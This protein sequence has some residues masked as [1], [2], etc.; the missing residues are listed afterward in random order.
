MDILERIKEIKEKLNEAS[1]AYYVN[2]N[3]IMDDYE[4]DMLMEELIRLEEE[5]PSLKTLDSP[6]QRIGGEV[7]S[8]FKKVTHQV[9]MMSLADA[10]SY[11]ELREWDKRVKAVAADATYCVE[12]KIDG[13]SVSLKYEDG[14]LVQ[15]A[16][17]GNGT[18]GED[19]THNV[20]TIKSV[21]LK[22]KTPLTT[23][24]RG[25]IFMPKASFI[26]LNLEREENE[27]E[28]FANCRNAAAGSV[29][30]L[31]SR[32]AAKR[33]L[34]T[35]L[36]YYLD[37]NV[38]TQV[39][40]LEDMKRLGFKVNPMYRHCKTMDEVISYIEEM[41]KKRPDLPY[42]IDGI[43]LKVNEINLH[44]VIGETVKYPKWAIAY[45]F[46]PE[47]V[48]TELLDITYQV[49]RTG[50][51]TPVANF[52][53][54]FVQGSSISK[55]TLHNEDY[56]LQKDVRI[57]DTIVIRKAG[58]VIPEVVK[59]IPEKRDIF[60]IPFE[61]IKNC[62]CCGTPLV[63]K[64]SEADWYCMNPNC[65]DKLINKLI[66]FASKP[67]YNIDSLGDKLCQQ[68][69]QAGFIKRI[70]DIFNLR[71]NYDNLIVLP[72]LGEKSIDHLLDAIEE[73]K[74]N[75]L[76]Q[77]I[78]GLGIRHV[79]AK[80]AKSLCKKYKNIDGL[81]NAT[82]EDTVNIPDIGEVIASDFI[83]W[84]KNEDNRSLIE[85]LRVLG[86]NME[87]DLGEIK[88]NYFTGKKCVLTGTLS[89]MGRDEAKKLIESFGGAL[90]E[91]VSKKTDILILGENPGSKYDKAKALGIY[92]ME[93]KEFL[94]K[95]KE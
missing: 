26:Q 89:S 77:L 37:Q 78:F 47:E 54:V 64:P 4:Y 39:E 79:G 49:G 60:S 62:P 43:V 42:D 10:F 81:L 51:I 28:L 15:G 27:E 48:H 55:A 30:Q 69:F 32:I 80:A 7:L 19:I 85:E 38:E 70:P 33:N 29:R 46:P 16:T 74:K 50:V 8:K 23:E 25:E 76:D 24:V 93:E 58:D 2:D 61:M 56:I 71:F 40:A 12:L 34:D 18:V 63:R 22:L 86:L 35:F 3:P 45:K 94:E 68:L 75:N 44:S 21:P 17:R 87:Y 9:K 1:V 88:E 91:S 90:S 20:K 14:V 11:D 31:D 41:G 36:Y 83:E 52:K 13:L 73:S 6:T 72:G 53:P 67:C 5:N 65:E 57:G 95:I 84:M 59:S 82:Y 66:H 92:I